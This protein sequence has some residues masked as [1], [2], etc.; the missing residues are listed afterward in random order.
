MPKSG[1]NFIRKIG[2]VGTSA[3]K[4]LG[5]AA[6][7]SVKEIAPDVVQNYKDEGPPP[8]RIL[9][10]NSGEVFIM[11]FLTYL[12]IGFV[13]IAFLAWLAFFIMRYRNNKRNMISSSREFQRNRKSSSE[14]GTKVPSLNTDA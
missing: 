12:V 9:R 11:K 3:V 10:D 2:K 14:G 8:D 5:S 13:V 6:V 7:D 4:K 1:L